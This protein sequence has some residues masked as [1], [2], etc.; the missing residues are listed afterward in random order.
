[1]LLTP[2]RHMG[3][4]AVPLVRGAAGAVLLARSLGRT[5]V[6]KAQVRGQFG[7]ALEDRGAE[8]GVRQARWVATSATSAS[9]T[10]ASVYGMATDRASM[11]RRWLIF[12]VVAACLT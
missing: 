8:L 10:T 5:G 3:R 6:S 7:E 11:S 1:M 2:Q 4:R 9:V 12:H